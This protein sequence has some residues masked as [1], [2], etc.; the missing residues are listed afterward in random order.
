M[1]QINLLLVN[2]NVHLIGYHLEKP[3]IAL[4]KILLVVVADN[5]IYTSV[6][7]T[8]Y[9]CPLCCT[10]ETEIAQV[11]HDVVPLHH[12]VPVCDES[13]VH[14]LQAIERPVA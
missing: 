7:P 3:T 10:A 4:S 2:L 6:Q 8:A 13:F 14:V 5:E 11:E 12:V 9:L 1:V